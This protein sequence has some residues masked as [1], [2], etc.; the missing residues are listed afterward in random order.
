M[1]VSCVELVRT[2][3]IIC[4]VYDRIFCDFPAKHT[5]YTACIYM[6]LANPS[7]VLWRKTQRMTNFELL[8]TGSVFDIYTHIH[9][10]MQSCTIGMQVRHLA[11]TYTG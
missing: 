5:V 4:T 6:V 1:H 8:S 10:C 7:H 11:L 9:A 2:V 3:Y